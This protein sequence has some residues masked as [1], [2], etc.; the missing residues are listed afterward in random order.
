ML[1]HDDYLWFSH[2]WL[3]SLA[4][5]RFKQTFLSSS[6]LSSWPSFRCRHQSSSSFIRKKRVS[7][8]IEYD[9][10]IHR[11]NCFLPCKLLCALPSSPA[12]V[13]LCAAT[14]PVRP[15]VVVLLTRG[16]RSSLARSNHK[17]VWQGWDG[18]WCWWCCLF[19]GW[20]YE[21]VPALCMLLQGS[22]AKQ[23]GRSA[24]LPLLCFIQQNSK[25]E[26]TAA[27]LIQPVQIE[28]KIAPEKRIPHQLWYFY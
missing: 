8:C 23:G 14:L 12:V 17:T 1:C 27:S 9:M 16:E 24:C 28:E 21:C 20:Y 13:A 3:S 4:A 26:A 2:L 6:S 18:Q 19:W 10:F 11:G 5:D 15:R 7:C 25:H 22:N